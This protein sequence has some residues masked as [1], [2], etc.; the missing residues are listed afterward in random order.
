[1]GNVCAA[2]FHFNIKNWRET[3]NDAA[4]AKRLWIRIWDCERVS[5]LLLLFHRISIGDSIERF[6][7]ETILQIKGMPFFSFRMANENETKVD[8]AEHYT[9]FLCAKNRVRVACFYSRHW[10]VQWHLRLVHFG[11]MIRE[12]RTQPDPMNETTKQSISIATA[13]TRL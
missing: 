10:N 3:N 9:I 1:M 8:L 12:I 13:R 5:D 11:T 7:W 6:T 2:L 4:Y